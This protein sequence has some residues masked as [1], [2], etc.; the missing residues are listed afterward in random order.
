MNECLH[1]RKAATEIVYSD[2]GTPLELCSSCANKRETKMAKIR[3][4]YPDSPM[5]P[6]WFDPA[7]A[8]ETWDSE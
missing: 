7:N 3:E 1:C 6:S 2:L 4:D 5:A 8:G